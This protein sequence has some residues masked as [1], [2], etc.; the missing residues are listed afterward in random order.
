MISKDGSQFIDEG[1]VGFQPRI[2]GHLPELHT[3]TFQY[4]RGLRQVSSQ[5]ETLDQPS[6]AM[7]LLAICFLHAPC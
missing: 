4:I 5:L 3:K 2:A 6:S 1:K 7:C